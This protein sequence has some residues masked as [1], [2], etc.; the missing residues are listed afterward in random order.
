MVDNVGNLN[1]PFAGHD[2]T[3]AFTDNV[4]TPQDPTT[5]ERKIALRV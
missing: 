1:R 3:G 2:R 4:H 5:H